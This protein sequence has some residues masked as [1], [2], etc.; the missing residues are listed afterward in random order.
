MNQPPQAQLYDSWQEP[1]SQCH[2]EQR[3]VPWNQDLW[4]NTKQDAHL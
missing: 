1:Q 3:L 4:R 2:Q